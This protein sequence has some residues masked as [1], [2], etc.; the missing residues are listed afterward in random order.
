MWIKNGKKD[1]V[2]NEMFGDKKFFAFWG[3]MLQMK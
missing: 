1:F 2:K 3:E